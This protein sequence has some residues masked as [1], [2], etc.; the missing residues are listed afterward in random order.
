MDQ[1]KLAPGSIQTRQL[2]PRSA[3]A[4]HQ[5]ISDSEESDPDFI[6]NAPYE[7]ERKEKRKGRP[8]TSQ[9]QPQS[10]LVDLFGPLLKSAVESSES[11]EDEYDVDIDD[12]E[13]YSEND[14]P[15]RKSPPP[16]QKFSSQRPASLWPK[17]S[18]TDL[19]RNTPTEAT[20]SCQSQSRK[21]AVSVTQASKA[22]PP[23]NDDESVTESDSEADD[24]FAPM[25]SQM[26]NETT[27]SQTQSKA[28][29]DAKRQSSQ[30]TVCASSET[31]S[32]DD[33]DEEDVFSLN[34][35]PSFP[36]DTSQVFLSL[37]LDA[38][39]D[40]RVPAPI[41]AFL[42]EYQRDGIRFFWDRYK[43][44]GG[45]VLGD[46]MGLGKTIQVIS[47]LTAIMKKHND[48]RDVGRRH[49][50]VS[51]LQDSQEW[52]EHKRL[53]PANATWPTCLVIAPST[54]AH[55]WQREFETWGYFEVGMFVGP[56]EERRQALK[57]FKL[58]RL[59]ILI[60]SFD[61][62]RGDIELLSDLPWSV[63][64]EQQYK[65]HD[66][67]WTVL[68]WSNPGK[69]DSLKAWKN[70]VSKPLAVGQS[71]KASESERTIAKAVAHTLVNKLLPLFFLRRTKDLIRLQLP[72]KIDEVVFCPLT[73]QQ[74]LVYKRILTHREERL[75]ING[76]ES[77]G[78][79]MPCDCGSGLRRTK[80][81]H[82][83]ETGHFFT[84]LTVLLKISNHLA[85]ILPSP[86]DTAEQTKRNREISKIAFPGESIPKYGP[87]ILL[88]QFCGKWD[89]LNLLLKGW[90]KTHSDKVLIFT[91]SVKLLDMLDYH[92]NS[93]SYSFCR[94][95]G[96]TKQNE[97]MALIDKFNNDP[98]IFIFLISTL[99]GG[100]GLNLTGANKV[101]IFDPNW[102]PA[103]DLQA[104]DRAYRFG[105]TR[106]V[107]V[108]RL[109][110]A[111]SIEELIYARQVY[112]QQMMKIG[113]EASH[114]TR[115]F[116]GVQGD[117]KR[118]GELFG[119]DNLFKLQENTLATKMTALDAEAKSLSHEDV[120]DLRGLAS[121]LLD[122]D[123]P[124]SQNGETIDNVQQILSAGSIRYTHQNDDLFR[125]SRMEE[126][127]LKKYRKRKAESDSPER[128][129][130]RG[131]RPRVDSGTEWP[132]RRAHHKA[133]LSPKSK[134]E[135]RQ[136]AMIE[137]G[138]INGINELPSFAAKFGGMS[139]EEQIEV[140]EKLDQHAKMQGYS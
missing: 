87:A 38:D 43:K 98:E 62:A 4:A 59:D 32:D 11:E 55:N 117:I 135:A 120:G 54:V 1:T 118:R 128:G 75:K 64:F 36:R 44:G 70:Y 9:N 122:D 133:P 45:G 30:S 7:Y 99:A 56:P 101:V 18:S 97:R 40:T 42:R 139:T 60:T 105:Q 114:Q 82:S 61:T 108:Y 15:S 8:K 93:N 49:K 130:G 100:T 48:R 86:D 20:Q 69:L 34:P 12:D 96:S 126:E 39:T 19:D 109:L 94:L 112:K 119:A 78:G 41:N 89:V 21:L 111:G 50:H 107:H 68:D 80:C 127:T 25:N 76:T 92:L 16:S 113:Y 51:R 85:L 134:I 67:L 137:I 46:D 58:G 104:M 6:N 33:F 124:S 66:E 138:L 102:N 2:K 136:R 90:Q 28:K 95:D 121:L 29:Y 83:M 106:D 23:A 73:P 14:Y 47:F 53:P 65:T 88:P 125:P 35:R 110:G 3:T 17:G 5:A 27:L 31:E 57:D 52:K 63:I 123:L 77:S 91:K 13:E 103:H 115:Y 24:M 140:I 129:Q 22:A 71:A 116:D 37:I 81:C 132:P 74:I 72:Q 131:S 79:A 84:Y 26:K 10:I